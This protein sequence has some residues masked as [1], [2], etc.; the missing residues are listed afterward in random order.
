MIGIH[1]T[2][3][4]HIPGTSVQEGVRVHFIENSMSIQD[5]HYFLESLVFAVADL[6]QKNLVSASVQ[7]LLLLLDGTDDAQMAL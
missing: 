5:M 4:P 2:L 3:K 7:P 1:L 6:C